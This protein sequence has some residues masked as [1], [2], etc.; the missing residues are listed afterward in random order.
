MKHS[1]FSACMLR[2]EHSSLVNL[3]ALVP[4]NI[5]DALWG[6]VCNQ[7][8]VTHDLPPECF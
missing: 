1:Q 5:T 2:H 8:V 6:G 4:P 3:T 7:L